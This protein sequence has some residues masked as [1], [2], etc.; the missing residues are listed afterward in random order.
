MNNLLI[1]ALAIFIT[2]LPVFAQQ[3]GQRV[4]VNTG[5]ST[6]VGNVIEKKEEGLSISLDQGGVVNVPL[7]DIKMVQWSSGK[8]KRILEGLMI[9]ALS[10]GALGAAVGWYNDK[11]CWDCPSTIVESTALYGIGFGAIGLIVGLFLE[12]E[13]W[14][15]VPIMNT[16]VG[17]YNKR[18][19]VRVEPIEKGQVGARL[20]LRF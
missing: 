3:V 1:T 16:R 12:K 8:E 10:G 2:A 4:K 15:S 7:D 18:W 17:A 19:A 5:Y 6:I 13:E 11:N 9:G 14:V 20:A